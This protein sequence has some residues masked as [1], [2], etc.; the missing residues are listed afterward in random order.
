MELD[1][2]DF[3]QIK[4]ADLRDP[5]NKSGFQCGTIYFSNT[6]MNVELSFT[7]GNTTGFHMIHA[8][9]F[10]ELFEKMQEFFDS[11]PEN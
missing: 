2:T 8:M 1:I 4:F 5:F 10:K 7:N 11:M 9:N 6:A 3:D